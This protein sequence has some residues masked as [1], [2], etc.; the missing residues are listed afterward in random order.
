MTDI[1]PDAAPTTEPAPAPEPATVPYD[2]FK[3]QVANAERE[4]N[5][6]R[7]VAR[8]IEGL[9]DTD[10][11]AIVALADAVRSGDSEA[12]VNW[13][14][15]SAEAVS[16]KSVADLIAERQKASAAPV[17]IGGKADAPAVGV[18]PE[19]IADIVKQ[20]LAEAKA[21]E[22][23]QA[24]VQALINQ[25]SSEMRAANIEP[26]SDEGKEVIAM[27]RAL[28]ARDGRAPDI[29]LAIKVHQTA[30]QA[31]LAALANAAEVAGS[32]PPPAPAGAP[33]GSAPANL[34]PRERV[35]A[36]LGS[37]PA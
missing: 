34:T 33:A 1:A 22:T 9:A 16:G 11:E 26:S 6:Y 31:E 13:A 3:R 5:L 12:V 15:Q 30:K 17:D 27:A 23:Q 28:A 21:A 10:R 37:K 35:M 8:I 36:R 2:E 18:A 29:K 4:R 25:M 14:L 24:N 32:T 19:Q 7:P 20:A